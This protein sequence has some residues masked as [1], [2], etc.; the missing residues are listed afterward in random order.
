MSSKLLSAVDLDGLN[1]DSNSE[2]V[3]FVTVFNVIFVNLCTPL[4]ST[5]LRVY[6]NATMNRLER[7]I[8]RKES[9]FPRYEREA[10][11]SNT[12]ERST[13]K[14]RALNAAIAARISAL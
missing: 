3:L 10:L 12:K 7:L 9:V 2:S 6:N 14:N 4:R 11:Q 1:N 5:Q 8:V 13:R